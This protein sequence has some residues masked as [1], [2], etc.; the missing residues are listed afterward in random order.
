MKRKR[1]ITRVMIRPSKDVKE[2]KQ[3]KEVKE[4]E[5]VEKVEEAEK[6]ENF[7]QPKS[8]SKKRAFQEDD[9]EADNVKTEEAK[10]DQE[11]T[12][13]MLRRELELHERQANQKKRSIEETQE[14]IKKIRTRKLVLQ[15]AK[16]QAKK[17][18]Q[19]TETRINH[20]EQ[21]SK[22]Q[23]NNRKCADGNESATSIEEPRPK[24][25]FD[26]TNCM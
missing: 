22:T 9:G 18:E 1:S 3:S 19:E 10:M 24:A 20:Q 2:L 6:V 13:E 14:C 26:C 5:E 17:Q 11:S 12:A 15:D 25:S 8:L 7:K 23:I 4:T 21:Q 16:A